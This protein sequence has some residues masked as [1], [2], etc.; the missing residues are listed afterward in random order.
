MNWSLLL[1]LAGVA[2]ANDEATDPADGT[3]VGAEDDTPE[4][5][6]NQEGEDKKTKFDEPAGALTRDYQ[7]IFEQGTMSFD[8]FDIVSAVDGETKIGR[9]DGQTGWTGIN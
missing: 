4:T 7:Y 1:L 6:E 9:L 3:V 8:G 2:I 5:V